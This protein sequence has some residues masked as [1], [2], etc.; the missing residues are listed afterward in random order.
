M[1]ARLFAP[2]FALPV[3]LA[4]C[5]WGT[6]SSYIEEPL[7]PASEP[8]L[9]TARGPE[10]PPPSHRGTVTLEA[11]DNVPADV[12]GQNL[13]AFR[14]TY[15]DFPA[16]ADFAARGGTDT[17]TLRDGSCG[18]LGTVPRGFFEALCVQGSGSLQKGGTVS[19][20]KRDCACADVCP[21]TGQKICFEALDAKSYP[22]GRGAAGKPITPL[23]SVAADTS[24]LPMGTALYIPE[25]DGLPLGEG[26]TPHDGCV[27]VEDRGLKV[28]D[29]HIDIF[30]GRPQTTERIED[31]L[32]SNQ[33]V[34][35][36]IGTKR[37]E[38]L[39]HR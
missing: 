9:P 27:A 10:G 24:L 38:R 32:P 26:G 13:G 34:H 2:A 29:S 31:M 39:S 22:W 3:A 36:V 35:V 16:E 21:R 4:A 25:L 14:N 18:A 8:A 15:Y 30:T 37:C 20:A 28:R 17:V 33:G 5:G 19:F 23:R 11:K 7:T 1:R 12:R 6:G